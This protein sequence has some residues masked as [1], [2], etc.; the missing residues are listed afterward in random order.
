MSQYGYSKTLELSFD[1]A[2]EEVKKVLKEQGFGVLTEIDVQKKLKEK[3]NKEMDK[4]LILGACNPLLASMALDN[5]PEIGLF[6]PCNVIIYVKNGETVV[7]VIL[8]SIAMECIDNENLTCI[9][10]EAEVKLKTSLDNLKL[11]EKVI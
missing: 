4:Y 11:Y 8:P 7:S 3:L 2:V 10:D 9:K 5:E 1:E 6:L